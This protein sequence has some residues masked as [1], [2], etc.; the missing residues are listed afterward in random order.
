L[1]QYGPPGTVHEAYS[2]CRQES[3]PSEE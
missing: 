1:M 3:D 2:T